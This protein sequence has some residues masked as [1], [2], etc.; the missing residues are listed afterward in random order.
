MILEITTSPRETLVW[1]P[2]IQDAD[3]LRRTLSDSGY[4]VLEADPWE[5]DF[6]GRI[7]GEARQEFNAARILNVEIGITAHESLTALLRAGHELRWHSS[8]GDENRGDVWGVPV[9]RP[10][11]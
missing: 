6:F 1:A 11:A 5:L 7:P 10:G 4:L 9:A 8:Q 2:T 3:E